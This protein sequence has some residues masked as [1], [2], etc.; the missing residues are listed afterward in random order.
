LP[1]PPP[2]HRSSGPPSTT[3]RV[4][5][6]ACACCGRGVWSYTPVPRWPCVTLVRVSACGT[7]Q[8]TP[9]PLHTTVCIMCI[10]R[11]R[12]VCVPFPH[13]LTMGCVVR[14]CR[15]EGWC[16]CKCVLARALHVTRDVPGLCLHPP[17]VRLLV[18]RRVPRTAAASGTRVPLARRSPRHVCLAG[19]FPGRGPCQ[20]RALEVWAHPWDKAAPRHQKSEEGVRD[21]GRCGWWRWQ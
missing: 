5:A 14:G 11:R 13:Q 10:M 9:W 12:C 1:S 3:T 15:L 4:P 8:T 18:V 16:V 19:P 17:R 21:G 7:P 6:M 20:Q 2:P